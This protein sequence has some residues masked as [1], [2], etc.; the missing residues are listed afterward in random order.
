M[1]FA[2]VSA[3]NNNFVKR[4]L[5]MGISVSAEVKSTFTLNNP[6]SVE[7]I[8]PQGVFK[9]IRQAQ[10]ASDLSAWVFRQMFVRDPENYKFTEEN[11]EN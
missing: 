8:T 1:A 3:S 4:S 11:N 7:V 6:K 9:S 10:K 5:R 2:N